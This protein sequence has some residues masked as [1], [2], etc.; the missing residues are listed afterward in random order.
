MTY[1]LQNLTRMTREQAEKLEAEELTDLVADAMMAHPQRAGFLS[2]GV[3]GA[4]AGIIKD[5]HPQAAGMAMMLAANALI[6]TALKQHK[7]GAGEPFDVDDAL[8]M[9]RTIRSVTFDQFD[10]FMQETERGT[11][12]E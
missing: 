7:T 10:R 8:E 5:E 4:V 3:I 9:L 1:T 12:P 6:F 2:E 11:L